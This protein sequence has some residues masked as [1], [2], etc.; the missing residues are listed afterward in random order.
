DIPKLTE[1]AK[2]PDA[3]FQRYIRK[4]V[5]DNLQ[6]SALVRTVFAIASDNESAQ[7]GDVLSIRERNEESLTDLLPNS[8]EEFQQRLARYQKNI[9]Q[10]VRLSSS[11]RIPLLV[12][13]QPEIT[14]RDVN[15]LDPT[16]QALLSALG[17][18][19]QQKM[20]TYYPKMVDSVKQL[21]KAFPTNL[22]L[23]NFYRLNDKFPTPAFIDP[24]HI[25][26]EGHAEMAEQLYAAIASLEKMQIIPENFELDQ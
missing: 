11:A 1:F 13:I 22:K 9:K 8:E 10:F 14:G 26:A 23:L 17:D 20:L 5:T 12:A 7:T 19:Y 21:E 4:S 18:D 24:I 3:Y 16:E 6:K 25:N 2:E 15:K